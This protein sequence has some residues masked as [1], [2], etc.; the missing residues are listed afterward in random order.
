[1]PSRAVSRGAQKAPRDRQEGT[2][3]EAASVDEAIEEVIAAS[4]PADNAYS[5]WRKAAARKYHSCLLRRR[6]RQLTAL[7]DCPR[8]YRRELV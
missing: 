8:T 4:L 7:S 1:M 3:L 6:K 5:V 2:P